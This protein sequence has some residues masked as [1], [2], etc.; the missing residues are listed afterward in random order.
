MNVNIDI[1]LGET[2][3]MIKNEFSDSEINGN[4]HKKNSTITHRKSF[5]K[6]NE[7]KKNGKQ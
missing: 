3:K 6:L 1:A 5:V 2:R 7:K 4:R